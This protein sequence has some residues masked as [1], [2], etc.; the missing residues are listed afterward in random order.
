VPNE[1]A[2]VQL[3]NHGASREFPR[4]RWSWNLERGPSVGDD[5]RLD[6][7]VDGAVVDESPQVRVFDPGVRH[8]EHEVGGAV[9]GD[10]P[11]GGRPAAD[12]ALLQKL[13]VS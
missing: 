10:D 2:E 9:F 12:A 7:D 8:Q 3:T 1:P 11:L 5:G 13:Y 4:N 6:V